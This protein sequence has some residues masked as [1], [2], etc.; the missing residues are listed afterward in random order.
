MMMLSG[1]IERTERQW[2]SLLGAAGLTIVKIWH[3]DDSS[4][5]NEAV[6]ECEKS[7]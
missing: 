5:G 2:R 4:E 1:G 3:A 6:I 7:P